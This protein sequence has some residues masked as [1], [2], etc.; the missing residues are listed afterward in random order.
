MLRLMTAAL[1]TMT[2]GACSLLPAPDTTESLALNYMFAKATTT[3]IDRDTV[4]ADRVLAAVEDARNYV[5]T[6]ETVTIDRL[7]Q[8]AL[9]RISGLSPADRV[10]VTAI[11]DNMRGNLAAA[12]STGQLDE[13]ERVALLDV[14]DWIERAALHAQR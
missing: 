12:L 8:G 10:L 5:D 4:S 9:E 14:L 6:G 13:S 11:V 2:L 1:L 3:L 7:Y